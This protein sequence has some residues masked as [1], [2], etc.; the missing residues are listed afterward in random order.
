MNRVRQ[1]ALTLIEI[2]IIVALVAVLAALVFPLLTQSK[3]AAKRTT[4]LQNLRQIG[5]ALAM[6]KESFDSLP[7]NYLDPLVDSGYLRDRSLL[8]SPCDRLDG[9]YGWSMA[10]CH[11]GREPPKFPSSYETALFRIEFI[12]Q[13]RSIDER[14][15]LVVD[16]TC[17]RRASFSPV[18][19]DIQYY[20]WG[21]ILRLR[22]DT[23]VQTG[24]FWFEAVPG[25]VNGAWRRLRLYT[26]VA[27]PPI[28]L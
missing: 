7:M 20:H 9:K 13:L 12:E 8:S 21:T 1:R 28:K 25:E 18:C 10:A 2:C 19:D 16:R 24:R 27:L 26:E 23:S 6:Y 15:A 11:D 3:I 17:G 14:A 5:L 4:S 22:E